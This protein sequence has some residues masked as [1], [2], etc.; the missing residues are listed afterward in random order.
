MFTRDIADIQVREVWVQQ[1]GSKERQSEERGCF[2]RT[3]TW[4]RDALMMYFSANE[5]FKSLNIFQ[6][7]ENV[8][9]TA[10]FQQKTGLNFQQL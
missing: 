8:N 9:S 6:I 7:A 3:L 1:E 10:R 5:M 4:T 2:A